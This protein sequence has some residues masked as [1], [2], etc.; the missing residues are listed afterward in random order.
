MDLSA[1]AIASVAD[2]ETLENIAVGSLGISLENV[3]CVPDQGETVSM[4]ETIESLTTLL[5]PAEAKAAS[6]FL[7]TLSL[8]VQ[9]WLAP[10][11]P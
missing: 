3:A 5:P 10:D 7:L 8:R 9:E 1:G 2:I 11:V 4:R 6:H